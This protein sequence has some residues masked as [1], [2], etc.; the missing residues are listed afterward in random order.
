MDSIGGNLGYKLCFQTA[1][2]R[3]K[4]RIHVNGNGIKMGKNRLEAF[5]DGVLAMIIT[6][7]VLGLKVRT[8]SPLP[9]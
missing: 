6:I 2:Y 5:S 1:T 4:R 9:Y 7:M 8:G 3:R